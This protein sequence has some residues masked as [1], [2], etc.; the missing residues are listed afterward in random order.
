MLC[1]PDLGLKFVLGDIALS[2][3]PDLAE[4]LRKRDPNDAVARW[5]YRE[6]L[7]DIVVLMGAKG[8]DS[9]ESLHNFARGA[10]R[11]ADGRMTK[12]SES[13][14]W[15]T[16]HG[17]IALSFRQGEDAHF[18]MR[19]VSATNGDLVCVQTMGSGAD[20]LADLRN[21]LGFGSCE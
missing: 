20:R 10:S 6:G 13:V 19:C 7:G 1:Q 4:F 8:F 21:R 5:A 15:L 2:P 14:Q 9:E 17:T 16:D 3:V 11:A 18:D 12:V